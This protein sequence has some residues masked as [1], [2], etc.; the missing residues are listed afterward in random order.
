[1]QVQLKVTLSSKTKTQCF[2]R[3]EYDIHL[4]GFGDDDAGLLTLCDHSKILL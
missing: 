1:M 4:G 3:I 2:K